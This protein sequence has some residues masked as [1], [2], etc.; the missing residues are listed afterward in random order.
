MKVFVPEGGFEGGFEGA[1]V[2]LLVFE[3][4]IGGVP[5]FGGGIG[6][7]AE[8]ESGGS[9][10]C[11]EIDDPDACDGRWCSGFSAI[12]VIKWCD[13]AFG[14]GGGGSGGC[15]VGGGVGVDGMKEVV[16]DC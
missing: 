7:M 10:K 16:S 8:D 15:C 2:G 11:S 9:G 12:A 14:S 5:E 3:G 1:E 13:G 4:I 6:E